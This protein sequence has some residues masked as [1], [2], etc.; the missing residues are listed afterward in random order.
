MPNTHGVP[1]RVESST[2]QILFLDAS[3]LWHKERMRG[4]LIIFIERRTTFELL[5][6]RIEQNSFLRQDLSQ[7]LPEGNAPP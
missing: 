5:L 2:P 7:H 3:E 4:I 6:N 1:P